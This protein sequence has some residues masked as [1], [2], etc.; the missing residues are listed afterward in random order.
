[1]PSGPG[2]RF[3]RSAPGTLCPATLARSVGLAGNVRLEP[4]GRDFCGFLAGD[5]I[6]AQAIRRT[7]VDL[8]VSRPHPVIPV[9]VRRTPA[10]A[11]IRA[12]IVQA[13]CSDGQAVRTEGHIIRLSWRRLRMQPD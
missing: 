3:R 5:T 9:K 12:V 13:K 1:M 11:E 10:T 4:F 6:G 2:G 7:R 8:S